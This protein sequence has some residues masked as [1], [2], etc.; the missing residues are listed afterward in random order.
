MT[1]ANVNVTKV[2]LKRG[3]TVQNNN[4]TGVSGELTIDTQLK[5]LRVHDG[6]TAGGNAITALGAIGSYSNTNTA[7]YL[8]SQSITSANIGAFQT[9][10]NSNAATQTTSINSINANVGAYQTFANSNA[11]TQTTS[12]NSINANVGAYQTFANANAATQTTEINSLQANITAA[13]TAITNLTSNAAIQATL[14]DTLTGNAATQSQ[15][16]DTLTSNA[17]AQASSLTTLLSNAV[18]QQT[19]LIDLVANAVTQA[20][21]IASVTGTYSNANVATYLSAFDGNI[22]P[23]ANVTYSLGSSTRQWKDLW[24]SNNTIYIGNVPITVSNGNLLVNGNLVTGSGGSGTDDVLRANVGAY[25]IFANANAATQATSINTFNA[26]LG[27]Y[28]TFA[29]ANAAT[30][31]TGI[32]TVNANVTAANAAIQS[33]SA[34]IGTL[35]AEAPGALDTLIELG[36]ALGNNAS[37]SATMVTWLGNITSNVTAANVRITTLD[38]NLGTATTNITTL[39]SN[40][41]TQ[42]TSIN[43]INNTL[44]SANVGIG[45]SAG[46]T[47]QGT[48]AVAIGEGAGSLDQGLYSVAIG[49]DAG[50]Q[51][52]GDRSVAVGAGAGKT[53]QGDYAVAIGRNAGFTNQGNNSIIINATSGTLNQTTANTFTVAPVRNDVANVTSVMFYNTTSKEITYGNTISV[54]GN[55]NAS[56]FNFANGVNILSTVAGTYANAN[57]ASYLPTYSGN[58][59][60]L[61]FVG[62]VQ[63][64]VGSS[65]AYALNAF[66]SGSDTGG[67]FLPADVNSNAIV[68]GYTI[69][70]NAGVTLTV[71]SASFVAGSPIFVSVSTTPTASSFVYPVTVYSADYSPALP[72]ST[73]T[74][75]NATISGNVTAPRYLFAN[76]VNILSTVA[77][78]YGN[79]QVASYL[80]HFDGDIEFTSSTARIGNVDVITVGDHIRSPAYQFSNGVSIF[81]GIT[82]TANTGNITFSDTTIGT[83]GGAGQGIILNSAGSGE[84]AIL[85]Y[86][87]INNSNPGYWLHVGDGSIGAVN[88][89]G[90]IS[91]DYNNGLDSSRGTTILGYA[92]WDAGG[93]GNNNRGIGVHRQ[94]GIY[95][96]DDLYTTKY[97]EFDLT[98]GNANLTNI[99][100]TRVTTTNGVYWANG[101]NYASTVT[102][103]YSNANVVANLA[104][105]VSNIVSSANV[106]AS[107]FIGN[108]SALT[109]ITANNTGNI[110]GTSS[111]VTLVAGAYSWKFDNTGNLTLP[112]N[113]FAVN[114]ANT[115]PINVVTRF[116]SAWT[117]PTGNSTQS[118][119]VSPSATYYLWVDCNIPNGI[120]AW[121]ATATITNSNVPV[122]GAQYAWVYTGGGTPIDFTSIP[123][124][125]TGTANTIVRSSVAPS[126]TTNRF[127]F[128]INNTSGGNVTVRY[129]W[130]SIS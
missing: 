15:V 41:A 35:V 5:T 2:L 62:A 19:S 32:S 124:Q 97:I 53:N 94:F 21:A 68:A 117:V 36:T 102:G 90:N 48:S 20:Q 127:D 126:A 28:Q 46:A 105:Y 8:A 121:N 98:S 70:S 29:N 99:A 78:T 45:L 67:V 119:T 3:N 96:N 113:T 56:Q 42:A 76:G 86:V 47:S 79:T 115:A 84:I 74:V 12:I 22:L 18:A 14:L 24:V 44:T 37:F 58:V 101:V 125:F 80:L 107:Y 54:A 88:N 59:R 89:T 65:F 109:G 100:V 63:A 103:T 4:Y 55:I 123:N 26:N 64:Q 6:V 116:E 7:A 91:I 49:N 13:N 111:N 51:Y 34:N 75:G 30:Q 60:A 33:L 82:A 95:K 66:G 50:A 92:W 104:N 81:S 108:G 83:A 73:I 77:G 93:N 129:G 61:N 57:V 118:F 122:V 25:Q 31:A 120:L 9:F 71:T 112:G 10:A 87:G 39:F 128:G 110:Y 43:T 106:T 72:L 85:D 114:Y 38:A 17:A 130:V 16:L 1:T 40:A 11:A 27:A 52:Q 69:V 23:S